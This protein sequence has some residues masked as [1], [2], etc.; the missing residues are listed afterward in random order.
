M[1]ATRRKTIKE[2]LNKAENLRLELENVQAE[3]QEAYDNLSEN[4]QK[5][6]RGLAIQ[7][8]AD[9]LQAALD[10]MDETISELEQAAGE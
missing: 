3:E 4:L 9:H 5:S 6:E 2:L 8:S 7:E 1:N 10:D